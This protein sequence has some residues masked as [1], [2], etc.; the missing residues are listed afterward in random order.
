MKITIT[1]QVEDIKDFNFL[2]PVI[3]SQAKLAITDPEGVS[4]E[5]LEFQ[6]VDCSS[7]IVIEKD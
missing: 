4:E 2:F 7:K 5:Y 6:G 3:R 1:M